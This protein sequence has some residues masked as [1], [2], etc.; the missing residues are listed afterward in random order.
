M[1]DVGKNGIVHL[2][3]LVVTNHLSHVMIDSLPKMH[4]FFSLKFSLMNYN[5]KDVLKDKDRGQWFMFYTVVT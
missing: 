1:S 4:F 5:S 2:L 3:Q